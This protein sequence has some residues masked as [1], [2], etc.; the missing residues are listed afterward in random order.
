MMEIS[1]LLESPDTLIQNLLNNDVFLG[2]LALSIIGS[3]FLIIK[4]ISSPVFNVLLRRFT[5]KLEVGVQDEAYIWI[6]EWLHKYKI[7]EKIRRYRVDRS[8]HIKD[9][10]PIG[11]GD[12]NH[13]VKLKG[14]WFFI[15]K[16]TAESKVR[17]PH[18]SITIWSFGKS[19]EPILD[20]LR[21][22]KSIQNGG[23]DIRVYGWTSFWRLNSS[24]CCRSI[25][26]VVI[27]RNV[28]DDILNDFNWFL[29]NK[30]W[31]KERGVPYRRG[32]L[33]YG[34]PGTGKTSL[35]AALA[36]HFHKNIYSLNLRSITSDS[37]LQDAFYEIER[38]SIILIED[39]DCVN[40]TNDRNISK[41]PNPRRLEGESNKRGNDN[42]LTGITL[43]GLLNIID[44]ISAIEDRIVIMTTNDPSNL[45]KALTR[46]GRI[47]RKWEIGL[48]EYEERL[49]M[50]SNF[51]PDTPKS[52][53]IC[54]AKNTEGYTTAELQSMFMLHPNDGNSV[55]QAIN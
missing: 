20:I 3:V 8:H 15:Q 21:E 11:P 26:T 10:W 52:V 22:A 17:E 31:Y 1:Q 38:N 41:L 55:L 23:P 45:D 46:P 32:Y 40:I 18:E 49:E 5:T 28:K 29:N 42:E 47:D 13:L 9:E 30:D 35:T 53:S 50:F 19:K 37:E 27:P 4:N 36:T 39:I 6:K 51:F 24:N 16:T 54:V 34:P 14:R 43:S 7:F 2:F 12:G 33:F 48:P 25:D 44:G